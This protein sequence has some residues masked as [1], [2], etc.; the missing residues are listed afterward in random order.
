M[1]MFNLVFTSLSMPTQSR[2]LTS[3]I[4]SKGAV[5]TRV[6][7]SRQSSYS[8]QTCLLCRTNM[9]S[10][11]HRCKERTCWRDNSM[12]KFRH[13]T[14]PQVAA[15]A[16]SFLDL[17]PLHEDVAASIRPSVAAA[18]VSGTSVR[19][20]CRNFG[21]SIIT[22]MLSFQ[23]SRLS[24]TY[25]QS[26]S[27]V[28]LSV[29]KDVRPMMSVL[30][31]ANERTSSSTYSRAAGDRQRSCGSFLWSL[32]FLVPIIHYWTY[33]KDN[34]LLY[35]GWPEILVFHI[36]IQWLFR[37]VR[38]C[39]RACSVKLCASY[40]FAF[41]FFLNPVRAEHLGSSFCMPIRA[42]QVVA[43]VLCASQALEVNIL[44]YMCSPVFEWASSSTWCLSSFHGLRHQERSQSRVGH[45]SQMRLLLFPLAALEY[46]VVFNYP[47]AGTFG[48]GITSATVPNLPVGLFL[49]A[50]VR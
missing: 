28:F 2:A 40:D 18:A 45:N 26:N 27:E 1:D 30:S 20:S 47:L 16:R 41:V 14:F 42:S 15:T 8:C 3:Y 7:W 5:D 6:A 35:A 9:E 49:L 10:I 21:T 50:G 22:V 12:C 31:C 38:L 46:S 24:C 11:I 43:V 13:S 48:K 33:G 32:L 36:H 37:S 39:L 25:D 34:E 17:V 29:C 23:V 19:C 44:R 4:S